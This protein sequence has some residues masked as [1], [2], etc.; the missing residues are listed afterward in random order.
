MPVTAKKW[1]PHKARAAKRPAALLNSPVLYPFPQYL[2]LKR[3][4]AKK[5]RRLCIF[6]GHES[7]RE[8][9]R[10][11]LKHAI[12]RIQHPTTQRKLY[13]W[14]LANRPKVDYVIEG[15]GA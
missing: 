6:C 12:T 4:N 14:E 5:A 15:V 10:V 9:Q 1:P 2:L 13:C 11:F 3:P 7:Y 8:T